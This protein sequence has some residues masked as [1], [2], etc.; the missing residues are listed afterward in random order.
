MSLSLT[1]TLT[2]KLKAESGTSK[3]GKEWIKQTFVIDTGDEYNPEVAFSCFGE[4]KVNNLKKFKKGANVEVLFNVNS[5]EY[6]GK[7]YTNIDAWK[8]TELE[9]V[10]AEQQTEEIDDSLP[11]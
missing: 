2:K 3:A 7:Y 1:G 4:E 8:V 9:A 10:D 6:E 5:R 11:F